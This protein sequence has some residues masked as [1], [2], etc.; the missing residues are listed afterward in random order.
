MKKV[1]QNFKFLLLLLVVLTKHSFHLQHVIAHYVHYIHLLNVGFSER[2][3]GRKETCK[4]K[5]TSKM[6][7]NYLLLGCM[8]PYQLGTILISIIHCM[9]L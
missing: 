6:G 2:G 1:F 3:G 4:V 7:L 8:L 5:F 9:E